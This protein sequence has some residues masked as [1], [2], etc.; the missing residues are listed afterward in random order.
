MQGEPIAGPHWLEIDL[1]DEYWIRK[2]VID[3]EVA[4]SVFWTIQVKKNLGDSWKDICSGTDAIKKQTS[5]QHIL[6]EVQLAG[7][8]SSHEVIDEQKQLWSIP[9]GKD[10]I[11]PAIDTPVRY[12]RLYIT[13][14]S[15]HWGS[16]VWRFQVWGYKW[17]SQSG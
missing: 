13:M 14:P 8:D 10:G 12:V 5:K 3:W 15:T 16:S 4:F 11:L 9:N 1:E 7:V 6:H 17:P 2:F